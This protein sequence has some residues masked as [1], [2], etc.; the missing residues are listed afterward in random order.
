MVPAG[1]SFSGEVNHLVRGHS[2]RLS[3]LIQIS[4]PLLFKVSLSQSGTVIPAFTLASIF[5]SLANTVFSP[6]ATAA[7]FRRATM[8]TP[9]WS[10]ATISPALTF[11]P[12]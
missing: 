12:R 7:A 8:T 11:T 6:S 9:S 3:R 2:F 1:Y 4:T 10:P 5:F